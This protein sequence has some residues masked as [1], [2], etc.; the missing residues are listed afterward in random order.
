MRTRKGLPNNGK[1]LQFAT[2]Y[3]AQKMK[4]PIKDFFSKCDQMRCEFGQTFLCSVRS[5]ILISGVNINK[6]RIG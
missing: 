1:K 6:N 2:H 5:D 4:F 3:T